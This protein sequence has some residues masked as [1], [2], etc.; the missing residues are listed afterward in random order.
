MVNHDRRL[1]VLEQRASPVDVAPIAVIEVPKLP[2]ADRERFRA[3]LEAGD[4][5][6]VDAFFEKHTG[7]R[8]G[9]GT[10]VNAIVVDL[11][12]ASRRGAD[13]SSGMIEADGGTA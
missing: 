7:Q 1:R 2:A 8:P 11:H 10:P 5:A 12:P 6:A 3:A 9:R 13:R 4:T